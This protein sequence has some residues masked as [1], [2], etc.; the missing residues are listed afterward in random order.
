MPAWR[1]RRRRL[2]RATVMVSPAASTR[3]SDGH[4]DACGRASQ[5][6]VSAPRE[7]L[8]RPSWVRILRIKSLSLYARF[9]TR[10]P[11]RRMTCAPW[12][13]YAAV[14]TSLLRPARCGSPIGT[15]TAW[16]DDAVTGV[17]RLPASYRPLHAVP[18]VVRHLDDQAKEVSIRRTRE[19]VAMRRNARFAVVL[20]VFMTIAL[21]G[22]GSRPTPAPAAAPGTVAII[23]LDNFQPHP[24]P[25]FNVFSSKADAH[26]SLS[27]ESNCAGTETESANVVGATGGGSGL[28]DGVSHG[29]AVYKELQ[30]SLS[31]PSLH[32]DSTPDPGAIAAYS[33]AGLSATFGATTY[34]DSWTY[35]TA[36][37]SYRLL[38]GAV[39]TNLD[40]TDDIVTDLTA[41]MQALSHHGYNRFV[42]NLSFVV[43]PCDVAGWLTD[44]GMDPDQLQAEYEAMIKSD[45]GFGDL[46]NLL[47]HLAGDETMPE[48][49]QDPVLADVTAAFEVQLTY[50]VF[51]DLSLSAVL[52]DKKHNF[53]SRLYDD[54]KKFVNLS[55]GNGRIVTMVGAAGNGAVWRGSDGST[56]R[57]QLEFPF[58]PALWP[59][60][61]SVSADD[62]VNP[63]ATPSS[64]GP[65]PSVTP[66]PIVT[67]DPTLS[68]LR[69][70]TA[71]GLAAYSNCGEVM[72][73]GYNTVYPGGIGTSFA[74][75]RI[76]ALEGIYLLATGRGNCDG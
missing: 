70:R 28:P 68:C 59:M 2:R 57:V 40:T 29:E 76:S 46:P 5:Y 42:L 44:A 8:F 22:C 7:K 71:R 72:A 39:D 41:L 58:A 45:P 18:T 73:D 27:S 34:L 14:R 36:G 13:R 6:V 12:N 48:I 25:V 49:V 24:A 10:E 63:N 65:T 51:S 11:R 21:A 64:T 62:A 16:W 1:G 26:Q 55:S 37:E 30:H 75:P 56:H 3:D 67:P 47:A 43:I 69:N 20:V 19:G 54:Q 4:D 38:L 61:V 53:L 66:I 74:A 15:T 35:T 31:D 33:D 50:Q 60:V 23:V 52:S 17:R 9:T 32:K